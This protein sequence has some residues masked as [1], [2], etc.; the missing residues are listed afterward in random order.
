VTLGREVGLPWAASAAVIPRTFFLCTMCDVCLSE[1]INHRGGA[2]GAFRAARQADPEPTPTASL[3][4]SSSDDMDMT[5]SSFLDATFPETCDACVDRID[6]AWCLS[7]ASCVGLL[8][9]ASSFASSASSSSDPAGAGPMFDCPGEVELSRCAN[10]PDFALQTPTA[11]ST[12]APGSPLTLRWTGGARGGQVVF[13]AALVPADGS[14]D[15][16]KPMPWMQV[17]SSCSNP[18]PPHPTTTPR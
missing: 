18:P 7:T 14:L 1:L 3:A 6:H 5:S 15:V 16:S 4:S 10:E 8:A 11:L 2:L 12:L 13:A 17:S 9:D